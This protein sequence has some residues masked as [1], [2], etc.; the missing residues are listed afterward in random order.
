[1]FECIS[2]LFLTALAFVAWA[3]LCFQHF[4]QVQTRLSSDFRVEL[5]TE[6]PAITFEPQLCHNTSEE[7]SSDSSYQFATSFG[8]IFALTFG[9]S[10]LLQLAELQAK[11]YFKSKKALY[12][13]S[14]TKV[15]DPVDEQKA[16]SQQNDSNPLESLQ[17]HNG[18]LKEQL[19][20]LQLQCLE[21]R[22][23]LH[24]LE[25]SSSSSSYESVRSGNRLAMA[26]SSEESMVVWRR[27]DSLTGTV[28]GSLHAEKGNSPS[29]QNIYIT[30]S[31]FH[32][33]G[34]VYLTE[35]HVNVE[36][37]QNA[38]MFCRRQSEFLQVAGRFISGPKKM[39][40]ITGLRCH[41]ILI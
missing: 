17:D 24:E 33:N 27:S 34:Q 16:P 7:S 6:R 11:R 13:Q 18:N 1:M 38:S 10:K 28:S 5:Y 3:V 37:S 8:V 25:I 32:I 23:L 19:S 15:Q 21:M 12:P 4:V 31:H 20:I 39:P 36:L 9:L 22:E 40:M 2:F 41:N 29:T 26:K 30:N 14:A 35:N